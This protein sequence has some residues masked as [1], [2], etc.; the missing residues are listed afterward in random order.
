MPMTLT[1]VFHSGFMLE[2]ADAVLIFDFWRDAPNG[3]V[4]LTLRTTRK[5]VYFLTSHFHPDHFNP[6]ILRM[7]VPCGEKRVIL[8]RDI[9]RRR[10]AGTE[11][12]TAYLRRGETYRDSL[13]TV[14]A[15]PSTDSGVSFAVE[16]ENRHIFHAGDLNNWQ[17]EGKTTPEK[18]RKMEG[19]FL[20]AVRDI[21]MEYPAFDLAMFPVDPRT[22]GDFTRGARQWL[23]AVP[24]R[25]FAPMHFPP[26]REQAMAFGP[27]AERLGTQFLYIHANGE[28]IA[29]DI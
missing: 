28:L 22:G 9:Y 3:I 14:R 2:G 4:A 24:T 13:I 15:F 6:E 27:E 19:D 20:A 1:Y 23:Q 18:S 29:D 12:V 10:R 25:R 26:A 16:M 7:E 21:K 17:W 11:G 5:R 8:S